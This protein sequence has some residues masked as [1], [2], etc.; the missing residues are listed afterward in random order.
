MFEKDNEEGTAR[1]T[2]GSEAGC[3]GESRL[4]TARDPGTASRFLRPCSPFEGDSQSFFNFEQFIDVT[5]DI[6]KRVR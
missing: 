1:V 2:V 5:Q 6:S 3:E 4:I